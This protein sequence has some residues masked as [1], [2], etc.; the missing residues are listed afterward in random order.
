MDQRRPRNKDKEQ[1]RQR[2]TIKTKDNTLF[3]SNQTGNPPVQPSVALETCLEEF[4]V[5]GQLAEIIPFKP[6]NNL[7]F[8]GRKAIR[9]LR[10][11][12]DIVFKRADKDF[13]TVIMNT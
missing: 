5:K 1:L 4:E 12:S 10:S 6:R 8:E 2:T 11:N 13:T 9:D 3:T 7:P